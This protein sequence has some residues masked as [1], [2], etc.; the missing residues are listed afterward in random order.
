MIQ[1]RGIPFRKKGEIGDYSHDVK[2]MQS[3]LFLINENFL[4][5]T[6]TELVKGSGTACLRSK[7]PRFSDSP[8]AA[9]VTTGWSKNTGGFKKLDPWV[10][11]A[12][13]LDF[14]RICLM[15]EKYKF[16]TVVF[17]CDSND[18]SMLGSNIFKVHPSVKEYISVKI[19]GINDQLKIPSKMT[20]NKVHY[21]E[22][23]L[24]MYAQVLDENVRLK[25]GLR[26]VRS[27]NKVIYV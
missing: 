23:V 10:K 4:D 15:I 27:K 3:T 16:K 2:T 6:D 22:N 18:V 20:L 12:I 5:K 9:G 14:D 17:S 26:D 19:W 13:D 8:C 21:K 7:T 1:I 24:R 11:Y 25:W